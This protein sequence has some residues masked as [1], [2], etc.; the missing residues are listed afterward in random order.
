MTDAVMKLAARAA[1]DP[2]FLAFALA[3]YAAEQELDDEALVAA[4]GT[5]AAGLASARLC[6]MP[7]SDAAGFRED[8]DRIAGKFGLNR[9]LLG[10]I[11][12]NGLVTT[13]LR[14]TADERTA[15]S[16]APVLAARDRTEP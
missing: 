11:A 13:D 4:L 1:A 5:T 8:V 6:P 3:E 16:A 14:R 2:H 7:R 9:D 15:E 12:R 10:A